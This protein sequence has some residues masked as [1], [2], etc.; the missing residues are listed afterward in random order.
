MDEEQLTTLIAL[1]LKMDERLNLL[2]SDNGGSPVI[3]APWIVKFAKEL[4]LDYVRC[5]SALG[6][7]KGID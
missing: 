2:E 3:L 5:R 6:G 4:G 1:L 7:A